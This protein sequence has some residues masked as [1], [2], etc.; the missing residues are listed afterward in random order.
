MLP[1][2]FTN[3]LI[4]KEVVKPG[5]RIVEPLD[6]TKIKFFYRVQKTSS[7][8]AVLDDNF[9]GKEPLELIY[10]KQFKL[11]VW[12]E[13]LKTMELHEM[14]TFTVDPSLLSCYP[15]VAKSLRDIEK[16]KDPSNCG[17]HEHGQQEH[18][19]CGMQSMMKNGLGYADLDEFMKVCVDWLIDLIDSIGL[20]FWTLDWLIGRMTF[21]RSVCLPYFHANH[22]LFQYA[23]DN[24][25]YFLIFYCYALELTK[26]QVYTRK[27]F[28]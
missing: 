6:E 17:D 7:S 24:T 25:H 10:G 28:K 14:A 4:K 26:N 11:E 18:H 15:L 23:P 20:L 1:K 8:S 16:G 5:S 19:C 3:G 9:P 27:I 22:F 12:E 2:N 13:C 21:P